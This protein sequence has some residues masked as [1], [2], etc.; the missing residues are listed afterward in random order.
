MPICTTETKNKLWNVVLRMKYADFPA[1]SHIRPILSPF[2]FSFMFKVAKQVG[3][4]CNYCSTW[5]LGNHIYEYCICT[6]QK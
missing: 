1:P 3:V 5:P 4:I 6:S 2:T